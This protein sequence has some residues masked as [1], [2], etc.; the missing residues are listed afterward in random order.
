MATIYSGYNARGVWLSASGAPKN[1][2]GGQSGTDVLYG[3]GSND[4]LYAQGGASV[5]GGTGDDFYSIWD[6]KN[7]I[8]ELPDQGVDTL[9]SY[10]KTYRLPD[11]VENMVVENA[12]TSGTGNALANIMAGGAGSQM[13]DGGA[14]DDILSGGAGDDRFIF[15]A[16]TGWDLITDFENGVDRVVIGGAFTQFTR[17]A[18]VQAAL[19]QVGADTVL[20]LSPTDAITFKGK[21]VDAFTAADFALPEASLMASLRLT[22][23]DEFTSFSGTPTGL[24]A[25]GSATWRTTYMW[26]NRTLPSNKE[27]E[28]YTDAT[29]GPNPFTL[30]TEGT[31]TLD[32][33]ATPTAGLPDG[34][35]YASGAI[36]SLTTDVQTYGLFEMRAKIPSG[37]G[38]WPAFWLL[39]ADGTWPPEIDVFEILGNAPGQI[40]TSYGSQAG[41]TKTGTTVGYSTVDLSLD[42]HTYAVSWRPDYVKWY[43][44]GT[45]IFSVATPADMHSPMYL[46]TNLAVGGT[47]SWPGPA[48]GV[49]SA[50]MSIDYIKAYQFDDLAGPYRP[51]AIQASM[52][53]GTWSSGDTLYGTAGNDRIESKGGSDVMTG[54]D[55]AD[56]FA[57]AAGDGRDTITDFQPGVDKILVYGL[58]SVSVASSTAGTVVTFTP[59]NMVTLMGVASLAP[60]DIVYGDAQV[61]GTTDAEL[62]DRSSSSL[63]QYVSASGGADTIMGGSGDDFILG[64]QGSDVLTGG[65]GS[66]TFAFSIWDGHDRITDFQSGVDRIMLR[67]VEAGT[68]WVNPSQDASGISGLEID[69]AEG[70]SIFLPGLTSLA[71]G[72]IVFSS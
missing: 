35:T 40:Y 59:G 16:G 21:S 44:D 41:G 54:G 27:V 61:S 17:F 45:E 56:V 5:Y 46:V 36:T 43:I 52:V 64:G 63:P 9:V 18:A 23:S 53:N 39:R 71:A 15:Q 68:V 65:A 11:N 6:L 10:V 30:H 70:Q 38:F 37:A 13:L 50:T 55:G 3:T 58:T 62:I 69:Y 42:Y 14:G 49:S 12:N 7:K 47:G 19:T 72:D 1:W 28:Y 2:I 48:D 29:V 60:G 20:T 34:L 24:D 57:F 66:D 32:I 33:T 25:N 22:F 51:P 8:I 4:Y 31:G 67:G 26:G